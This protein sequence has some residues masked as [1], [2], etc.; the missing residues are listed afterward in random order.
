[1]MNYFSDFLKP[2]V[3]IY[4]SN[5]LLALILMASLILGVSSFYLGIYATPPDFQQGENYRIIY[6]HVTGA[7]LSLALY[8]LVAL[9]SLIYLINKHVLFY[10]IAK[11]NA[12]IGIQFSLITLVTGSLWGRPTWGSFWVWDARLTSVLILFFLYLGYFVIDSAHE[13]R[14]K[15]MNYSSILAI[16]GFINIPIIR[17]SVNWW[18]TL[19]QSS[20][21]T[22]TYITL[23]LCIFVPILLCFIGL[24]GYSISIFFLEIR[25]NII[26]HRIEMYYFT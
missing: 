11:V 24:V 22:Q 8:S 18:N 12:L 3:Y 20:S 15:A 14:I 23:D 25:K 2:K 6:I 26:L 5:K 1:M 16:L 9:F 13:I 19:H 4:I 17:Y 21:V 7:W 10:L